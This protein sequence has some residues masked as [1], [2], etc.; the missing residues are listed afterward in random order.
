MMH[1][2]ELR[3]MYRR[4]RRDIATRYR[5]EAEQQVLG[6]LRDLVA[7]TARTMIYVSIRHELGTRDII[8]SLLE[9]GQP[10]AVPRVEGKTMIAACLPSLQLLSPGAFGV[11]TSDHP[12]LSPLDVCIAPGVAFTPNGHR[13]GQG[14]GYYDRFFAAHPSMWRIGVAYDEQ[15]AD[16]LPTETHDLPVHTVVTPTQ[17]FGLLRRP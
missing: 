16:A 8:A 4:A 1:K 3:R 10:I 5:S 11:P 13:L 7:P 9:R 6:R 15:I 14:G 12:P 2:A 17:V